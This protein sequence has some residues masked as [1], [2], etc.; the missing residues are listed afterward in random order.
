LAYQNWK[1]WVISKPWSLRWFIIFLFIRPIVDNFYYLKTFSPLASPLYWV[2]IL[3]PIFCTI[4]IIKYRNTSFP[5]DRAFTIWSTI[6][7]FSI[8]LLLFIQPNFILY[9]LSAVKLSM[10][11]FLY[12]FLRKFIKEKK[13]LEGIFITFLYSAFIVLFVFLFELIMHPINVSYSRGQERWAGS[14]ADVM[15]YAIYIIFSFIISLYFYLRKGNN[16]FGMKMSRNTII[17]ITVICIVGLMKIQ[18]TASYAVFLSVFLL[19]LSYLLVFKRFTA[20]FIIISLGLFYYFFG[21]QIFEESINPLIYRE[22]EVLQGI[23]PE[24]QAFHGRM[25]RWDYA[26]TLFNKSPIYAKLFGYTLSFENPDFLIG[27]GVHNDYFRIIFLTGYIGFLLFVSMIIYFINRIR[28]Q[29][30]ITKFLSYSFMLCLGLYAIST[31]PTYYPTFQYLIFSLFAYLT[32]PLKH[33]PL[34][35]ANTKR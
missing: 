5:I 22:V 10:P 23:R 18:H 6:I 25:F 31:V 13:D 3:T 21:Q 33:F 27:I 11:I 16:E 26:W 7:I 30:L 29:Q 9:L 35:D 4:G 19:F 1:K 32:L 15:N 20:L 14:F 28:K 2:G 34:V 24:T 12:F 17:I 8:F